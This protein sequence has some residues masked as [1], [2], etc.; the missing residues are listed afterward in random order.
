MGRSSVFLMD[1]NEAMQ[2]MLRGRSVA[3]REWIMPCRISINF[4]NGRRFITLHSRHKDKAWQPYFDD[5][6][7]DDWFIHSK[8]DSQKY[9]GYNSYN[10]NIRESQ[11]VSPAKE[12]LRKLSAQDDEPHYPIG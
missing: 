11:M 5:F 4:R 8:T 7:S 6:L 1:F 2:E 10:K 3:R 12:D 9:E